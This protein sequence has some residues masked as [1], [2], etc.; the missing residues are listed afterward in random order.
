[1]AAGQALNTTPEFW[2]NLQA[3]YDLAQNR[4]T[5]G[6]LACAARRRLHKF[7]TGPRASSSPASRASQRISSWRARMR[8]FVNHLIDP[9]RVVEP[10]HLDLAAPLARNLVLYQRSSRDLAPIRHAASR[11]EVSLREPLAARRPWTPEPGLH[12]GED[13]RRGAIRIRRV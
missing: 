13:V 10:L 3:A 6:C 1:M 12:P 11:E 9:H 4:P 7:E 2:L 5:A 8:G